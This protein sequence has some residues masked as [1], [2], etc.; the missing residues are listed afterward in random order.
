MFCGC[1]CKC[2]LRYYKN[3]KKNINI[4]VSRYKNRH[5]YKKTTY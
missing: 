4:F 3:P 1:V 2:L 5:I